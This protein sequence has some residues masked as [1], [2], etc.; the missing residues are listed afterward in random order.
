M[1]I[2]PK[3]LDAWADI[4]LDSALGGISPSDSVMIKAEAVA[5]P[6]VSVLQEKV[7]RAGA[8]TDIFITPPDNERGMV[9]SAAAARLCRPQRLRAVPAWQA[10]RY[11]AATKYIE[12]FGMERPELARLSGPAARRITELDLQLKRIWRGKR[13]VITMFPTGA[14]AQQERLPLRDYT[15]AVVSGS[16]QSPEAMKPLM[17]GLSDMLDRS[18]SL[19]IVTR[20]PG[21][22]PEHRLEMDIRRSRAVRT[23]PGGNIP[24][25]EAYTSPDASSVEGSIYLDLPISRGCE[26]IGGTLLRFRRGRLVSFSAK[27][28]LPALERIVGTDAGARR[29][30][31]VA[32][33]I[34]PGLRTVLRHP[35]FCE[36]LCG[37]MHIALGN[38]FPE[39]FGLNGA[40]AQGRAA[41]ADLAKRGIANIS[42]QHLDLVVSFRKGM[43][44]RLVLVDGTPLPLR[45][46]NW[47][48]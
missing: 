27:Q 42:A 46:G 14:G 44:G 21:G 6:L 25:G 40:T 39:A 19:V 15:D 17:A 38:S 2:P 3:K 32:F 7:L 33:G 20:S 10:A 30:G 24:C 29:L 48:P 22:G 5:W 31:E 43:A 47:A 16:V 11:E 23:F 34:N 9:W 26:V 36:K 4:L 45:D 8:L 28:G 13:Y 37:T 41:Y 12:I 1:N 35:L 18:S